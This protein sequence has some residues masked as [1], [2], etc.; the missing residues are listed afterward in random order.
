MAKDNPTWVDQTLELMRP[1]LP[2]RLRGDIP[3]V[4]VVRLSGIIGIV[5][6]LQLRPGL[7]LN[8]AAGRPTA[9]AESILR[10]GMPLSLA[11]PTHRE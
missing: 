4:P 9:A 1:V 7:V 8:D 3:I 5:T 6:P 11:E 2:P 10:D